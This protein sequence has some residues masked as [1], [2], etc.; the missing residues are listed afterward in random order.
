MDQKNKVMTIKQRLFIVTY[1][2]SPY[3]VEL[4][5]GIADK[6]YWDLYIVYIYPKSNDSLS[7][8][9][10]APELCHSYIILDDDIEN[11]ATAESVMNAADLV[12][13]NYYQHPA[14]RQMIER[15]ANSQKAWCFW[16]ER[17]GYRQL[18]WLG[19][20][21]RK[22]KLSTLHRS[23]VPI[24][25]IGNWAVEQYRREFGSYR[26]YFNIPYFSNLNRFSLSRDTNYFNKE[27]RCFLYSGSLIHRKGVDLLASAFSQLA[28]EF[29]FVK[30]TIMGEGNLRSWLEKQLARYRERV[31][32]LGFQ[33]W[34][35]LPNF[36]KA[37]D[38]LCVP[39]RY[40]GW[41]LVVPEGLASGLP[42]I[43]TNRTGAALEL[44]ANNKNGWLIT[45]NNK[46]ALYQAMRQA[47]LLSSTQLQERSQAA[48][49]SVYQHSLTQGVNRFNHAIE[50]TLRICQ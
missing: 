27:S 1:I 36:Y 31:Q 28:D 8:F 25:G 9:W 34:E 12:I 30:L 38:I 19:Y 35:D 18:G 24:W 2:P 29:P 4:F 14:S 43:G 17:T 26:Q 39:S 16:G 40:D 37:A 48:Q 13:F 33:S 50:E 41:A 21:Y 45:A 32:F 11:Y 46:E 10:Q 22:W 44:I 6:N 7:R 20:H 23:N 3:Q 47:T 49:M 5:N 42:V 15:R